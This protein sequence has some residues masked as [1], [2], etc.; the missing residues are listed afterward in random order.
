MNEID[1]L[2]T[3]MS[4]GSRRLRRTGPEEPAKQ[5]ALGKEIERLVC[6]IQTWVAPIGGP[7]SRKNI[8]GIRCNRV[9]A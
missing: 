8:S 5:C 1:G 9:I 7:L 3:T 6:A 2:D 4:I